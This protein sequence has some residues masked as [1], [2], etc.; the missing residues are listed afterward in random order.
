MALALRVITPTATT[1]SRTESS[2]L[3]SDR[4]SA[5]VQ[6]GPARRRRKESGADAPV[7]LKTSIFGVCSAVDGATCR[8]FFLPPSKPR[9]GKG[10]GFFT[11]HCDTHEKR[12][13]EPACY[14]EK[15]C[16]T[17]PLNGA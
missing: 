12:L 3:A 4:G 2:S 7:R 13:T 16:W 14:C 6:R 5:A 1:A 8:P 10:G 9:V 11:A 15:Q 17:L